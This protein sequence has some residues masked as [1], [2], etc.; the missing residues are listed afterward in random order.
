MLVCDDASLCV[1]VQH[2]EVTAIGHLRTCIFL[3]FRPHLMHAPTALHCEESYANVI[4]QRRGVLHFNFERSY[5][6]T[7]TRRSISAHTSFMRPEMTIRP[8][9]CGSTFR[10]CSRKMRKW[11][12][13]VHEIGAFFSRLTVGCR[14]SIC[15]RYPVEGLPLKELI[16]D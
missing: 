13:C 12:G 14:T 10:S 7:F 4:H 11:R 6:F 1:R 5:S 2:L 15:C 9:Q 16:N 3:H 8:A